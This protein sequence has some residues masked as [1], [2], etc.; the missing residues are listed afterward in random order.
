[1]TTDSHGPLSV[2]ESIA[3][4]NGGAPSSPATRRLPPVAELTVL[5]VALMLTGGVY[6]ASHL[7]TLPPLAPAIGLLAAG[8][9]LTVVA[10]I[11]L[12]R[13][14]PFAWGTFFLVARWSFAAYVVI[15]GILGFVFI[16][17]HTR[18]S[19]LTVL[20]LTLVVFAFDVPMIIAFTV[21]RYDDAT[22]SA[23]ATSQ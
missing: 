16:F 18:G 21:A 6:L 2:E 17:D 8:G 19:T 23:G 5:S 13:I 20:L 4:T 14:H 7:P 3:H 11:L 9:A 12:S 1:M 15:A 10:L 22:L